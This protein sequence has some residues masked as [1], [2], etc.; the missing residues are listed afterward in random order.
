MHQLLITYTKANMKKVFVL[1][2]AVAA[3]SLV[4]CN[5]ENQNQ[6][7]Q[8]NLD[9]AAQDLQNAAQDAAQVVADEA[10]AAADATAEAAQDAAD[11]AQETADQI[12]K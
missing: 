2:A 10:N 6:D 1:V 11:K 5:K 7:A 8:E 3:L 12:K 9:A 4:S